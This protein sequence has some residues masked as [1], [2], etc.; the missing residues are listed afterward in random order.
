MVTAVCRWYAV[1]L[2]FCV[3]SSSVLWAG[4][5][6]LLND[7]YFRFVFCLCGDS[8]NWV[9]PKIV[10]MLLC[11]WYSWRYVW[12]CL[13]PCWIE[14]VFGDYCDLIIKRIKKSSNMHDLPSC[15][16]INITHSGMNRMMAIV[17]Y[18]GQHVGWCDW[19]VTKNSRYWHH[20]IWN[21]Y[22]LNCSFLSQFMLKWNL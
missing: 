7:I 17:C 13:R 3:S 15:P 5:L 18:T 21:I 22:C 2:K 9:P 19:P 6:S 10:F 8:D 16:Q 4:L 12:W 11:S 14:F 20:K 1:F